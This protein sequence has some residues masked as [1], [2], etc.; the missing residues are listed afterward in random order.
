MKTFKT[1]LLA[2]ALSTA[3]GS[4]IFYSGDLRANA[5]ITNCGGVCMLTPG[6]SD[7]TWA[8]WT[9]ISIPFTLLTPTSVNAITFGFGGGISA[10][11]SVVV[12]GGFEPYLS[13][14][15]STG[16]FV[17]STYNGINCPAGAASV[18]GNCYDVKLDA[19]LLTTGSYSLVL[20]AY[21]NMSLAENLGSGL[22]IDGLTGLGN[23]G[24]N[25][26]LKYGLDLNILTPIAATPEPSAAV[27]LLCSAI[28][29]GW[30]LWARRRATSPT[31]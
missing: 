12:V 8:Q 22:L 3:Y 21:S 29:M 14:F 19:G 16:E 17:T 15:D 4:T 9:G 10:T 5:T 13:L 27:L 23:L 1:V 11:G 20:S 25:E 26:N 2:S 6:D 7:A 24:V 18:G 28:L 31:C 30:K